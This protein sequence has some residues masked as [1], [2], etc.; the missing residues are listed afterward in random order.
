MKRV[1]KRL[2]LASLL[3]LCCAPTVGAV[4]TEL[5]GI[6]GRVL[7]QA[8][9]STQPLPAATVYAFQLAD[10]SLHKVVTDR[11]GNFLFDALPAGLY[12][13]IA[14]KPGFLPGVVLLTRAT[15]DAYQFLELELAEATSQSDTATGDDFWSIRSQIPAD[16]LRDLK[17]TQIERDTRTAGASAGPQRIAASMEAVTGLDQLAAKSDSQVTGGRVGVQGELGGMRLGLR[18]DYLQLEPATAFG[19]GDSG[20]GAAVA[21]AASALS[22]EMADSGG[23][24]VQLTSLSNRLDASDVGDSGAVD[25]ERYGVK[26]SRP[27]GQRSRSDFT[28]QYTSQVNFHRH[29]LSDPLDIPESSRSWRLEG[30]Y[31]ASLNDRATIQ[32]GVRYRELASQLPDGESDPLLAGRSRDQVDLFGRGGL[33]VQSAVLLEYGLYT[34]LR[35]GSVSLVPRGGVVLQMGPTWQASTTLSRKVKD[36][37]VVDPLLDFV[38]AYFGETGSC[39]QNE[40]ACY[41]VVFTHQKS[42]TNTLSFGAADREYDD[43]RR[44][45]F[46]DDFFNRLESLYLVPGDRVSEVQ[47]A[48]SHQITPTILARLESSVGEGGG[49]VFYTAGDVSYEN[50]VTYTVTSLDTEFKSTSTG[51]F[52][53]FHQLHQDLT[54]IADDA[55]AD[56]AFATERLQLTVTQNLNV[57]LDLAA[58]WA[59]RINMELSRGTSLDTAAGNDGELRRRLLGGISIR[60]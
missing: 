22:L 21:G 9:P 12:R 44:L 39:D 5:H 8:S 59:L 11:Q 49:G 19:R 4:E 38:P 7:G 60:F 33:R 51:I 18:G 35:D 31:T 2:L 43:T 27:L 24:S 58:D 32:T 46:S 13:I 55:V 3:V 56:P 17:V 37:P 6:A 48:A 20:R 34:T 53:A 45:Y 41:Q 30:S 26:F 50:R 42:E 10:S 57:L 40:A 15:S 36:Q 14:H 25:F 1:S 54:G 47:F 28:A 52:L 16:V 29:E 23:T